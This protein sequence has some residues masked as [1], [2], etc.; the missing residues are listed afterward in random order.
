MLLCV[1]EE[2]EV[3]P[4]ALTAN[5]PPINE[6]NEKCLIHCCNDSRWMFPLLIQHQ[7][8]MFTSDKKCEHDPNDNKGF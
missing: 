7:C 4:Q 6:N 8:V 2:E 5:L 3:R 1:G